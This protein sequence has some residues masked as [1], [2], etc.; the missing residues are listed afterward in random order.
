MAEEFNLYQDIAGRTGGSIYIGCVGPVRTG[1]STFIKNFMELMILPGITDPNERSRTIDEMP[2]SSN[3]KTIMTTEPKFIPNEGVDVEFADQGGEPVHFKAKMIDCVGYMVPGAIGH[4]EENEN[5]MVKTPW[6]EEEIPFV[7]AAEIGTRKVIAEHSTVGLVIT[8]DG[9]VTDI[10]R[11]DYKQAEQRVVQEL[12]KLGKPFIVLLNSANP[13]RET[14]R[15]LAAQL[16]EEYGVQVMP[17]NAK[18]LKKEDIENILRA[19]LEEFPAKQLSLYFPGWLETLSPEHSLKQSM[20]TMLRGCAEKVSKMKDLPPVME[21]LKE[22]PNIK[23]IRWEGMDLC[24]GTAEAEITLQDHLF[25]DV[26]SE[27]TEVEIGGE[28]EMILTIREL[29]ESRREYE[30]L[31]SAYKEAMQRGYGIVPPM[32]ENVELEEPKVI[33]QGGKFGVQ[34][35]ATAPSVHFIRTE[36]VTEI[37][38]Y[39]GT[40][41][42]CQDFLTYLNTQSGDIWQTEIFGRSV[43]ELVKEGL[44]GKLQKM[45]EAARIKLQQTLEKVINEGRGN[46]I[47][48]VL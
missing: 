17:V 46:L 35:R 13:E 39:V 37:N 4:M 31:E 30:K 44:S 11:E 1:K 48:I 10:P 3:G 16:A 25:Y 6:F 22:N 2:Q 40:Q 7:Q 15:I 38:P 19:L 5:R 33:R 20:I 23:K 47:C 45:P 28:R 26:L 32:M 24:G 36:V 12:Q 29:A 14:V 21:A 42:Q 9:T 34:L 27:M 41:E 8:T 18:E 43:Q